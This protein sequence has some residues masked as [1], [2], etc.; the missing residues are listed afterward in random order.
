MYANACASEHLNSQGTSI[1]AAYFRLWN[2]KESDSIH[3]NENYLY[4]ST[5]IG[6]FVWRITVGIICVVTLF[7]FCIKNTSSR[8]DIFLRYSVFAVLVSV[9]TIP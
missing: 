4:S 2:M 6:Y 9:H 7:C 1:A 8:F 5:E 3:Y